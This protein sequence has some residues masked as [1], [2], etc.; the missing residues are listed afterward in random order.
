MLAQPVALR[1][2]VTSTRKK[3]H[4]VNCPGKAFHTPARTSME[5]GER[6]EI[7][8]TSSSDLVLNYF[9]VEA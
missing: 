8:N 1:S 7:S 3:S 4:F 9:G 6:H 2:G 5:A